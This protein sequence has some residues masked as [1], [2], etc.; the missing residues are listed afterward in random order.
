MEYTNRDIQEKLDC[1][2]RTNRIPHIIF[3]GDS[4]SG[5]KTTVFNFIKK[6]YNNNESNIKNNVMFVNCAHGKGI[7]F[8][9]EELKFFAKTNVH[10]KSGIWFKI[11]VLI[12]ADYLTV[13]AQ[14]ALRRCI[15][16]F[17]NNT[18]FFIVIE[19][20]NKLLTPIVSRFCEIYIPLVIE[21]GNPVNLHT[22]KIEQT[23]GFSNLLAEQ[24]IRN[25]DMIMRQYDKP[26]HSELLIIVNDMYNQGLSAF[27]FVKWVQTYSTLSSLQ[28]S[29]MEMYLSK[30]R[31]EYRCEKLL[32]LCLLFT[33][34]F[35][36][37]IDLKTLSFM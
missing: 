18:R 35:N 36:P 30:V 2:H 32:L 34:F 12:N 14:S 6:I 33:Y 24:S 22:K 26:I 21:N 25:V 11:I 4:G 9:R 28:K 7:K 13:D 1:F 31:L 20:K 8:I 15:E 17:S 3:H 19:N 37:D 29:T 16:R 5:K 23:Y 10:F 27:D